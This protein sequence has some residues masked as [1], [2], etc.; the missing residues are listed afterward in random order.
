MITVHWRAQF[1]RF[2]QNFMIQMW[3]G[4]NFEHMSGP[5]PLVNSKRN[6]FYFLDDAGRRSAVIRA[7]FPSA[8]FNDCWVH[9]S[10]ADY[11]MIRMTADYPEQGWR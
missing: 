3:N 5:Y 10:D 7:C 4:N 6:T 8:D 1:V 11:A 9:L 2:R